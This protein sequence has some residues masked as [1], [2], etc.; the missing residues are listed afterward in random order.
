MRSSLLLAHLI[1]FASI[2]ILPAAGQATS[3]QWGKVQAIPAGSEVR[4]SGSDPKSIRGTLDGVTDSAILIHSG[5]RQQS[6]DRGQI[7]RIAVKQKGHRL[8]HTLI[9]LAI[10]TGG[11]YGIG[12]GAVGSGSGRLDTDARLAFLGLGAVL[13]TVIGVL[14]PS[15]GWHTVY[16]R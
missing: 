4:V 15:G 8:R 16:Q 11:G 7:V 13:G 2:A 12:V 5:G 3:P 14:L 9:G 6:I 1:M 10:G